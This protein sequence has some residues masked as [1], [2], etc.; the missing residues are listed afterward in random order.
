ML[1]V[2]SCALQ[3]DKNRRGRAIR[4]RM[5]AGVSLHIAA[6]TGKPVAPTRRHHAADQSG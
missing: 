6:S 5:F 4:Q 1:Q 3:Y 2:N